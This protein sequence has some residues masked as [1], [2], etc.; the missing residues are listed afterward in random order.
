MGAIIYSA[1]KL[2]RNF[3]VLLFLLFIGAYF[4]AIH[5]GTI[6]AAHYLLP[7]I[8]FMVLLGAWFLQEIIARLK[9]SV[10]SKRNLLVGMVLVLISAPAAKA[11]KHDITMLKP[12]TL[13]LGR[14]WMLENIP[15][16]TALAADG[17]GYYTPDVLLNKVTDYEL[18]NLDRE[19]LKEEIRHREENGIASYGL[20]YLL[21]NPPYPKYYILNMD[22]RLPAPSPEEIVGQN[23]RYMVISGELRNSIDD[24][25]IRQRNREVYQSRKNL[26]EW[27][28]NNAKLLKKFSPDSQSHGP[29]FTIYKIA[30]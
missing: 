14:L 9:F 1:G 23:I 11:V 7:V 30:E 29:S 21:E 24:Q 3:A 26:Y 10:S 5:R 18:Y 22:S 6:A 15:D 25:I 27:I 13:W 17:M 16:G 2:K 8:P 19:S 4:I 20:K 28:R 12:S